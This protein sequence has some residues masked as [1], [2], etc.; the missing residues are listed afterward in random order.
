MLYIS[1]IENDNI[2]LEMKPLRFAECVQ[3]IVRMCEPE[4]AGKGLVFR[5]ELSGPVPQVVRSDEKRLR[6]VLI[7][8][9]GNAVKFTAA[10]HVVFRLS[11]AREMA[12]FEVEDTGPGIAPDEIGR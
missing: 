6:Q 5:H 7:N 4:A 2:T 9:I 1:H 3:Q 10:G 8:V 12:V 11:Y